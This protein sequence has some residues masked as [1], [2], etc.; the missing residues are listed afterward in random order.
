MD[1]TVAELPVLDRAWTWFQE[2]QK[3]IIWGTVAVVVIG[4]GVSF[5]QWKKHDTEKS[6]SAA[7]S[8]VEAQR[9]LL[10]GN[11]NESAE[12]YLK[13]ANEH[14]GTKAAARALLLAGGAYF[15]QGSYT[16]AQA[17]FQ[18]FLTQYPDSQLRSQASLGV[19]TCLDALGKSDEAAVAYKSVVDR[20]AGE[21][22]QAPAKFALARIYESQGKLDQ[23]QRLY[24]ELTREAGGSM[25]N[26]AGLKAGE[27]RAKLPA[28]APLTA[29]PSV[30]SL[31]PTPSTPS[32]TS[33]NAP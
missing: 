2:N 27:L 19:A 4:F 7:L 20:H 30:P 14:A 9:I 25:A 32:V 1:Q 3:Q 8:V 10:G 24:E 6:A 21:P 12:A 17:Q 23:A 18:K 22:V 31:I 11:R 16:E 15:V 29:S 26:E 13:V 33:T 28:P 5:Y